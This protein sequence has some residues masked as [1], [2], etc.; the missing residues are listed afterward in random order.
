MKILKCAYKAKFIKKVVIS[1]TCVLLAGC[2]LVQADQA[3]QQAASTQ[4]LCAMGDMLVYDSQLN[5]A[6]K[7][8]LPAPLMNN[9]QTVQ[10]KMDKTD[11][12]ASY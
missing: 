1:V 2:S 4:L 5:D 8:V 9:K 6:F 12:A 11:A 3:K 10:I 7:S